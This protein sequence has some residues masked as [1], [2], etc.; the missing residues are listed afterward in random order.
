[1]ADRFAE[2]RRKYG[3][4]A[5]VG[6]TSGAYFSRSADPGPDAALDRLAQ[7]G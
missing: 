3:A 5:I 2:V 7:L 6:A 1:M 4:E